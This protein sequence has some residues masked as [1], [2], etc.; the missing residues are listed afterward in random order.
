MDS[1][2]IGLCPQGFESPRCRFPSF[3]AHKHCRGKSGCLRASGGHIVFS[4]TVSE[5][6]RRWTRNPLGSARRGSNPLGVV[7][8]VNHTRLWVRGGAPIH[9]HTLSKAAAPIHAYTLLPSFVR[10]QMVYV[11]VYV[12]VRS[13]CA[14]TK[15]C[16]NLIS[17]GNEPK[18]CYERMYQPNLHR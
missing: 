17:T 12:W 13:V 14:V 5:R 11:K 9:A 6:L 1:K 3:P 7:F 15:G 4:D 18:P 16:I 2:S 10:L 8:P